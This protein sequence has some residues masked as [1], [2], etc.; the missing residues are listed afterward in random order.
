MLSWDIYNLMFR[1]VRLHDI[2]IYNLI[3]RSVRLTPWRRAAKRPSSWPSVGPAY[4]TTRQLNVQYLLGS[5]F[6]SSFLQMFLKMS[7]HKKAV[8]GFPRRNQYILAV[9]LAR[10]FRILPRTKKTLKRNKSKILPSISRFLKNPE[11]NVNKRKNNVSCSILFFEIRIRF[12]ILR[13][14]SDPYMDPDSC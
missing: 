1:S 7:R 14:N 6:I 5:G 3:F 8:L 13:N 11:E 10:Q 9:L 12:Q 2:Y 4:L